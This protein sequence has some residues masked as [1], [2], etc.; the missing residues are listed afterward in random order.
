MARLVRSSCLERP[1]AVAA[2]RD[3][4]DLVPLRV[5]RR[6]DRPRGGEGDLVLARPAAREDGHADPA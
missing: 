5:E 2:D 3:L 4:G 6:D 1:A